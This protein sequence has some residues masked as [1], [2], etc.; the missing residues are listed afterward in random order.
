MSRAPGASSRD[1]A[2]SLDRRRRELGQSIAIGILFV[3][4]LAAIFGPALWNHARLASDPGVFNNDSRA[5]IPPF[6]RYEDP[7]P[8]RNDYVGDY[9]LACFPW[10][11]RGMYTAAALLGGA[12]ALSKALPYVLLLVTVGGISLAAH[13]VGGLFAGWAAAAL[14]LGSSAFLGPMAGGLPRSFAPPLLACVLAGLAYGRV[15]LLI[16]CVWLGALFYPVIAVIAGISLTLFLLDPIPRDRG[17]APAWPLRKRISVLIGTGLVALM[18]QL[19]VWILSAK[20][21]PVIRPAQGREYPETGP[22][23][24]LAAHNRYPYR[25]PLWQSVSVLSGALPGAGEPLSRLGRSLGADSSG[26]RVRIAFVLL[27]VASIGWVLLAL[28]RPEA[29]RILI[30]PVA[31]LLGH[32]LAVWLMPLLYIP[33]RYIR[34]VLPALAIVV[35]AAGSIG[36]VP[37]RIRVRR[38]RLPGRIVAIFCAATLLLIGGR[39][40]PDVGLSV[41][42]D[43]SDPIYEFI[44]SLPADSL[45]AG[46]PSGVLD[47]VP[48]VARRT[49]FATYETHQPFHSGYILEM[50]RRVDALID[51]YFATT[52]EPLVRLQREFGVTHLLIDLGMLRNRSASYFK[53]FDRRVSEAMNRIGDQELEVIRQLEHAE[54]FRHGELAVLDLRRV[55]SDGSVRRPRASG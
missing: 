48:Y 44:G 24:R 47:N 12:E 31:A 41:R 51:A 38:P 54:V 46:W 43:A 33:S 28:R 13:R 27:T 39:G 23:G 14:C 34:Y 50:R 1:E 10:G 53:P 8:F 37:E 30:L 2:P 21:G 35:L 17:I 49:A 19:P 4:S 45:V 25:G 32:W 42:V 29:R 20:Y 52:A 22:G 26:R 40:S 7:N 16:A 15:R 5:Q 55:R 9:Y 11:Y 18:M 6:F 3:G 36:L